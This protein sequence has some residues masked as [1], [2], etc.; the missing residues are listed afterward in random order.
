VIGAGFVT[1]WVRRQKA[2]RRRFN[3]YVAGTPVF[4]PALFFGRDESTRAALA[5]VEEGS[6]VVTGERRIGKTSFLHHLRRALAKATCDRR[7]VPVAVDLEGVPEEGFFSALRVDLHDALTPDRPRPVPPA[8]GSGESEFAADVERVIGAIRGGPGTRVTL[9]LIVD[10]AD[11]LA[12]YSSRFDESLRRTLATFTGDVVAL[13]AMS[14]VRE[15]W[16][17]EGGL[18]GGLL[19]QIELSAFTRGEAHA[20]V[21]RPVAGVF[22]YEPEAV[23]RILEL[24]SR[25]PYRIQKLCMHAVNHMLEAGRTTVGT[26]DV[27][28]AR[29][30]V[31]ASGGRP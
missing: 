28:A 13:L 5:I 30:V 25:R 26:V 16:R 22:D 6:L 27:E 12:A 10:E 23:E 2:L 4:D 19:E 1:S 8:S 18:L 20:L 14:S 31:P 9:A 17:G 29:A 11:G 3:P 24:S 7:F 15:S 21:T